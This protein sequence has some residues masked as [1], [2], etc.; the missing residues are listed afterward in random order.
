MQST[1]TPHKAHI[2]KKAL[3]TAKIKVMNKIPNSN[4]RKITKT[5][6]GSNQMQKK[7]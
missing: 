3:K 2:P 4:L 5:L 1:R 7:A 6:E